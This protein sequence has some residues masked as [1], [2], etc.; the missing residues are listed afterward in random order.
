MA[1]GV[2][3]VVTLQDELKTIFLD[4]NNTMF[5]ETEYT[6]F[7][8]RNVISNASSYTAEQAVG[9]YY[10]TPNTPYLL[11]PSFTADD[12]TS[13]TVRGAGAAIEIT[14][15]T[16]AGTT[17]SLT[18]ASINFRGVVADVCDYIATN[19]AK[20]ASTIFAGGDGQWTITDVHRKITEIRNFWIGVVPLG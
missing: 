3:T 20:Q 9:N 11:G 8:L 16:H 10:H 5:K 4:E 7:I 19:K 6:G 13:Y 2:I 15:G 18:G 12:D 14:S 1:V 17:I